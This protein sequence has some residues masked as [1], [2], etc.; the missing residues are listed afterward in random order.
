N[1]TD[2]DIQNIA[3]KLDRELL[4]SRHYEYARLLG[5]L[6]VPKVLASPNIPE[7]ISHYKISS[8]KKWGDIKHDVL[9]N[10]PIDSELL[11]LLLQQG[12]SKN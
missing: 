8:G 2:I 6:Q 4:R 9:V 10:Q 3:E 5:Q 11:K 7:I 12:K 1:N